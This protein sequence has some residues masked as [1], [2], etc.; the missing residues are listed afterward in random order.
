MGYLGGL[1]LTA[2]AAL[3]AVWINDTFEIGGNLPD[4]MADDKL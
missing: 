4:D 2:V 1:V 3:L